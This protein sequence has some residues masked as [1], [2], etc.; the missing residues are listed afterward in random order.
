MKTIE[1]LTPELQNK[2][3]E[4]IRNGL[5][6]VFD[7]QQYNDFDREKAVKAV[8]YNYE[9][10]G[11]DS[12]MVLVAENPLEA[13]LLFN[14]VNS[15]LK[16]SQLDSQLGSQLDSQ[17][18]S[19]LDSQLDSQLYSQLDSQLRSQLGSQL[20]S[21]LGSQLRSQLRSQLYSQLYS[22]LGSQLRSQLRSQ[23]G[24]QLDSQLYSQL[25]SQ[26]G[27]QLYSQLYSQLDSQLYSQLGKYNND[28][29][30]TLNVYSN[31]YYYWYEFIRKEFNIKIDKELNDTFQKI[32]S[33]Q[34][35]SGVYS[36]IFSKELCIVSKYPKKVMRNANFELHNIEGQS[37]EWGYAN[38]LTKFDA[39]YV[40]GRN[41]SKEQ[42]EKVTSQTLTSEEFFKEENED[43]KS[44]MISLMQEKFGEQ[45]IIDFFSDSLKEV[46]TFVHTKDERFLEGTTLGTNIGVYTLF[47]GEI[48]NEDVAYVRCYC[49]ST[50]RMFFLGV[51]PDNTNA[52]D[53]IASL[54]RVPVQLKNEIKYIQRQGERFST[55]FTTVG[56][57]IL[58][59]LSKEEV[60][61]SA[62]ISGD[63][64]FEKM[65]YE[66]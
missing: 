36:A 54:Y 61:N 52:K 2:I 31:S 30:F 62:T 5:K 43:V 37:V 27:S 22:Q 18:G 1:D 25:R 16:S 47:K 64:Y 7:G 49:P 42:F 29:L 45:K 60:Q 23:L 14:F 9:F 50:D 26:L 41:L 4:Y 21:Q 63:E 35:E 13:Q 59:S 58:L 3:P 19:Q 10:C 66:Y 17:L 48:S 20:R 15:V 57:E 8:N 24:S 6:G 33:L 53:A 51:T 11:F 65:K 34:R 38:E 32:F 56:K 44:A 12:P 28:Y 39:Y 40:N 46:D 55:V